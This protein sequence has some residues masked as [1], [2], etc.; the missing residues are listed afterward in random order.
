MFHQDC[1]VWI[2]IETTGLD[3]ERCKIIQISCMLSDFN[4]TTII[5]K[6]EINIFCEDDILCL[7]DDWCKQ[8]H[9]E[10]G[11]IEKVKTSNI[12]LQQAE[13]SLLEFINRYTKDD[14]ILYI[15]GNSVH[16]DKKFIDHSFPT[17]SKRLNHRIIDITSIALL[18]K[19]LNKEIY[20]N[21]PVKQY[22][23]TAENDILETIEE[24]RYYKRYF[25]NRFYTNVDW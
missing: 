15:A 9:T 2:D 5:R 13:E 4:A 14:I 16:F 6:E 11:L 19:A 21:R 22:T 24:Y 1:L 20:D 3:V 23:H 25:L 12:T 18:C 7:M 8:T 10:S 17:L